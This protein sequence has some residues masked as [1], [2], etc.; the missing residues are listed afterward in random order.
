MVSMMIRAVGGIVLIILGTIL[1]RIGVRGVAGSGVILD[2]EQARRDVEPWS[3]MTGGVVSD[4][5][6][7]SGIELESRS[8]SDLDFDEKLRKLEKLYQ[9]GL[10]SDEEYQQK[11][12]EFLNEDW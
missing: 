7:E 8:S 4:A 2:P 9:D 5:L 3:R 10:L 1:R 12:S 6:D 11:R